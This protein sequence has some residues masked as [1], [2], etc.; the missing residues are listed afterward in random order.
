MW[1]APLYNIFP[2]YLIN[3]T[4]FEKMLL[5]TKCVFLFSLP[6]LSETFLI[7]RGTE[8]A[9]IKNVYRSSDKAPVILVRF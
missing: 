6:L 2:L 5:N 4:I 9:M 1:P 8:R 7:V 3:G